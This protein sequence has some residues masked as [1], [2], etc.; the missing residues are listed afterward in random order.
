M[1]RSLASRVAA[2]VALLVGF[3]VLA[4]VVGLALAAVAVL[5]WFLDGVP[6]NLWVTVVSGIAAFA[7]LSGIAPRRL[8]FDPPGPELAETDQ[9]ELFALVREVAEETGQEMP[10][11]VYLA[12]DVNAAVAQVGGV[13]GFGG[14]RVLIVGLPLMQGLTTD[15][16]RAVL[17][18]EFGHY[19]G[20]DVRLGPFF[21]RTYDAVARTVTALH[22]ADSW[23]HKP[24]EAYGRFFLRR[25]AAIKRTQEF[26]ADRLAAQVAGR[27]VNAAALRAVHAQGAAFE[28]Y[29]SN[30]Y[31]PLLEQGRCAPYL[32]G[33]D[34]TKRSDGGERLMEA[35]VAHAGDGEPDPYS[36]HPE[37]P[38][39]LAALAELPDDGRRDSGE[40]ALGLLH[41]IRNLESAVVGWLVQGHDV[42]PIAWD[43]VAEQVLVPMWRQ[44]TAAANGALDGVTGAGVPEAVAAGDQIGRSLVPPEDQPHVPVEVLREVG[45]DVVATRMALALHDEGWQVSAPPG[46]PVVLERDGDRVEPFTDVARLASGDLPADE[47]RQRA[48][49]L[50]IGGLS[51]GAAAP[52]L[53]E[54]GA[55]P[56]A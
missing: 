34:A 13:L 41:G 9:P 19:H 55:A 30:E 3:Y 39:R 29:F 40:P 23:W 1:T 48:Q 53:P 11:S 31:A 24:F 25:S 37:L 15:Q 26:S 5:P 42:D 21:G 18:H 33:F 47:W 4:L 56:A 10:R 7:I 8:P 54:P 51:L 38:E 46:E 32:A 22:D 36:T 28:A 52:G 44:K 27:D 49:E 14:H 2:A 12:H 50:G 17:A 45:A 6:Q 16:L 43:E 35:V 20:G